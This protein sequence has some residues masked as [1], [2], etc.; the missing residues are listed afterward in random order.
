MNRLGDLNGGLLLDFAIYSIVTESNVAQHYP[1]YA[2][3]HPLMTKDIKVY[4]DAKLCTLFNKVVDVDDAMAFQQ[5][6]AGRMDHRGRIYISYDSTNVNTQAGDLEMEEFGNAKDD[7][8]NPVINIS[9][10]FDLTEHMPAFYEM[11]PG[12]V[13]DVSKLESTLEAVKAYGFRH[14]GFVLDRGYFSRRNIAFMDEN[15]YSFV[16]MLKG[17]K[18]MVRDLVLSVKGS[19]EEKSR[20]FISPYGSY[21]TTIQSPLFETD[22][23]ERF[24]HI[25]FN[26]DRCAAERRQ[27]EERIRTTIILLDKALMKKMHIPQSVNQLFDLAW[28][29]EGRPVSYGLKNDEV[30]RVLS[31]CGYFCI[32]TSE[33]MSAQEALVLYKGRD[34]EEKLF[35]MD[36]TFLGGD[37]FHTSKNEST[38]TKVFISFIA[39]IIR[40]HFHKEIASHILATGKSANWLTVPSFI[41]SLEK[42]CLQR[43]ADGCYRMP[44]P[45][46]RQA[47][48][49]LSVFG[50][51][52]V[53][54]KDALSRLSS[55]LSRATH[56]EVNDGQ[57]NE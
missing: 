27:L 52:E 56:K 28:S 44:Q 3:E 15:G 34:E 33:R 12:S 5:W 26:A 51:D 17:C 40:Q 38:S 37:A 7:R 11:Y 1:D 43:M 10:A 30:D 22:T 50:M 21:G 19:F 2:W 29:D 4:S 39:L 14:V 16:M 8:G 57:E 49:V 32:I 18:A 48:D 23:R 24:F 41:R 47:R 13:V 6:W 46:T 31:L 55:E 54:M 25:Y 9:I 35:M 45:L 20:D 53:M 36:K 42:I